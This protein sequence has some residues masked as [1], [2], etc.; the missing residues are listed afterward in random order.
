MSQAE[1]SWQFFLSIL[2]GIAVLAGGWKGIMYFCSPYKKVIS[3]LAEQ[4]AKNKEFKDALYKEE[5]L[6]QELKDHN[7]Q[8]REQS[9]DLLRIYL[10]LLNHLIDGNG[11]EKMKQIRDE[12]QKKL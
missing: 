4:K 10:V 5:D 3:T 12:V 11:I 6:L 8:L 2:G 9:K 1:I 7:D